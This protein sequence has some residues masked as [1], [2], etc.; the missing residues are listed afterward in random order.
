MHSTGR[1]EVS[2]GYHQRGW[3]IWSNNVQ[4]FSKINDIH[5][6]T[7]PGSSENTVEDKHQICTYA[8]YPAENQRQREN[9]EN[10]PKEK[11]TYLVDS[12]IKILITP[13]FLLETSAIKKSKTVKVVK[14][15]KKK[16]PT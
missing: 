14:C 5:Q 10:K 13:N 2:E 9:L 15:W 7:Y 1:I 12:R 6:T 11:V 4:E 8:Y 16:P 3:N